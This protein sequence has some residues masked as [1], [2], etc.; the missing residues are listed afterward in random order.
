ML[1]RRLCSNEFPNLKQHNYFRQDWGVE[2]NNSI[3]AK[4]QVEMCCERKSGP[5][6]CPSIPTEP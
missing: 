6:I 3:L 2:Y 5:Q 4:A 1:K